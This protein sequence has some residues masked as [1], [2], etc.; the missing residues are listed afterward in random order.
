MEK[1]IH[2]NAC[3]NVNMKGVGSYFSFIFT[4]VLVYLFSLLLNF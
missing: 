4:I 1:C 3:I 2:K